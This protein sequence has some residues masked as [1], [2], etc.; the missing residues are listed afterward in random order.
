MI[1]I[2]CFVKVPK[3][4]L[5]GLKL[6]L[7]ASKLAINVNDNLDYDKGNFGPYNDNLCP[8]IAFQCFEKNRNLPLLS[9]SCSLFAKTATKK[10][11]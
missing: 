9:A 11:L 7:K 1:K 6:P 3:L 5:H 8:V 2:C 10:I 4:L